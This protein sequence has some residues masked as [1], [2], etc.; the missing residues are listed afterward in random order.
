MYFDPKQL[1]QT[2]SSRSSQSYN[3]AIVFVVGGGNYHEYNNINDV[4][5][6]TSSGAQTV[7]KQKKVIYGTS[8]LLNGEEFLQ[9]VRKKQNY[10]RFKWTNI[11]IG[12]ITDNSFFIEFYSCAHWEK[13]CQGIECQ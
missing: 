8:C 10:I 12:L 13:N 11:K 5:K 4:L 3:E 2:T 9:Q 1:K 6:K 7:T